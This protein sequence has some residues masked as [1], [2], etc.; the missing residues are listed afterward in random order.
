MI[1][2]LNGVYSTWYSVQVADGNV[3]ISGTW[4]SVTKTGSLTITDKTGTIT[5]NGTDG[6]T[7]TCKGPNGEA[8]V[9]L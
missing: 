1:S 9:T 8:T 7:V 2:T 4:N 6:K 3:V 5:C